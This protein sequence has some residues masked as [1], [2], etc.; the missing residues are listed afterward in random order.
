MIEPPNA[1]GHLGKDQ[2]S[3]FHNITSGE[4][5]M[6]MNLKNFLSVFGPDVHDHNTWPVIRKKVL[7]VVV[8]FLIFF[9]LLFFAWL[10]E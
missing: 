9:L 6:Y 2:L 7:T 5:K 10:K 8:L 3:F 1:L 4:I